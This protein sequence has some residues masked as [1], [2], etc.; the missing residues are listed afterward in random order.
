VAP[1]QLSYSAGKLLAA[2]FAGLFGGGL[3]AILA[4]AVQAG[5]RVRGLGFL[6]LLGQDAAYWFAIVSVALGVIFFLAMIRRLLGDRV[7]AAI[8]YDGIELRG[9]FLSRYIPWRSL[10][11]LSLRTTRLRDNVHYKLRIESSCPPGGN[12]VHHAFASLSRGVGTGLFNASD[13][14]VMRWLADAENARR[15]ALAP[16]RPRVSAPAQVR[17]ERPSIGF[18]RRMG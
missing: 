12:A 5:E 10:E 14:G 8:R 15:A 2:A 1:S 13:E 7:A 18:G 17:A 3:I 9:L 4:M 16:P 6:R 11:G